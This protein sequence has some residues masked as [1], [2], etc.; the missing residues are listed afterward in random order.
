MTTHS[1]NIE[2]WLTEL[3]KA[4]S[5][6][7]FSSDA[8]R[9]PWRKPEPKMIH[10]LHRRLAW[11]RVAATFAAAAGVAVLFVGPSLFNHPSM[12]SGV[13]GVTG[14]S[15]PETG[16]NGA[17]A[18]APASTVGVSCD[19]NGDGVVD[20][21]DIQALVQHQLRQDPSDRSST[22]SS[23]DLAKSAEQLR[24]CLLGSM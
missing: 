6:G 22:G 23:E 1:G 4:R 3:G 21:R 16:T 9:Y 10:L 19:F 24:V 17:I 12:P 14:P 11:A 13:R 15:T 8:G 18:V 2:G 5:S 7:A 20:G